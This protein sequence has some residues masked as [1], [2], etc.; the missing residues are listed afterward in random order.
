MSSSLIATRC[1]IRQ[2]NS[3]ARNSTI[4][5]IQRASNTC[6]LNASSLRAAQLEKRHFR[7]SRAVTRRRQSSVNI[8]DTQL[9]NVFCTTNFAPHFIWHSAT[10]CGAQ[11]CFLHFMLT[12]PCSPRLHASGRRSGHLLAYLLVQRRNQ[13]RIEINSLTFRGGFELH[14]CFMCVLCTR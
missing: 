9:V 14:G 10:M 1:N 3:G 6:S 11:V 5:F 13:M 12:A 7:G 8:H 4:D 2:A